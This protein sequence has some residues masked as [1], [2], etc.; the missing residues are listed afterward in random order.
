MPVVIGG[1]MSW[2]S[3]DLPAAF[4][5][6]IEVVNIPRYER[7]PEIPMPLPRREIERKV[8]PLPETPPVEEIEMVVLPE[9]DLSSLGTDSLVLRPSDQANGDSLSGH[10]E[11][12]FGAA[13][14]PRF[15]RKVMPVY[16]RKAKS[17]N[18]EGTVIL[19]LAIDEHGDLKNAEVL[20][21]AGFGFDEEALRAVRESRFLPAVDGGKP[22]PC[23]AILPVRFVLN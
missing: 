16:P 1:G 12:R 22:V 17:L 4:S 11:V 3:F 18:K 21:C 15:L 13:N 2:N 20:Q 19:K 23:R 14:G 10:R 8:I 7:E 9:P 6:G 5:G